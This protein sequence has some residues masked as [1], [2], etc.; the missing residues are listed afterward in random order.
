MDW[1]DVG[2]WLK[3]N[4]G[5]GAA[6]VGSLL[7]GN[8]PAAVAAGVSLVSGATGTADPSQ[9]LQV[10]QSDPATVV[11]LRELASQ[12]DQNVREHIRAMTELQLKDAQAAQAEQQNTIR[13]GDTSSDPYVRQ[14]RPLMARQSWYATVAYVIGMELLH[15][16]QLTA[17]GANWDLAMILISPAAA[18]M[19]FRTWDKLNTAKVLNK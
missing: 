16:F 13:S 18:Y 9:A 8:V 2:A 4:A 14:T 15:G 10:F 3:S 19:G 17:G 11:K 7:S 6:L 1:K 5:T 12:D